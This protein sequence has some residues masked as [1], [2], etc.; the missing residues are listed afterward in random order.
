MS[1]FLCPRM[2]QRH[3]GYTHGRTVE[4]TV[5]RPPRD[6]PPGAVGVDR[7]EVSGRSL[8]LP[9]R[10]GPDHRHDPGERPRAARTTRPRR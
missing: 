3:D 5:R 8:R 7:G 6:A 1:P 2:V 10:G 4:Q 9:G